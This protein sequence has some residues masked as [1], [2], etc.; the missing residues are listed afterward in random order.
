MRRIHAVAFACVLAACAILAAPAQAK[1][2]Q[3]LGMPGGT[4]FPAADCP[5]DCQA[6]AELTGYNVRLGSTHNPMRVKRPGFVV[7]FT[8]R[9]AKP[10]AN[11]VSFFKTTYGPKPQARLAI[12]R[13]LHHQAQ[14]K[15]IKQTQAFD[16]EPYFGSTPTIAL[17]Q[18]FRVHKDDIIALTVPTWL[19][20]FAHNLDDNQI[21]RSSH[22]GSEC[23]ATN[24]P[25]AAHQQ[26]DSVKT[27]DCVYH[28]ARLLYSATFIG[29]PKP[30]NVAAKR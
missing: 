15:L 11:E 21:W 14:F 8:V 23:T 10:D 18:A 24:P 26:V 9:L 25:S 20:A 19:P 27:Y 6:I 28:G 7:A 1:N 4:A 29:D 16:L 17:R 13:S 30:T 2:V 5:T 22:S 12:I 3:E